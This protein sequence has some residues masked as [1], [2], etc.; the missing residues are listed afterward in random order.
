MDLQQLLG[1]IT[2][3]YTRA[4]SQ[5]G[6]PRERTNPLIGPAGSALGSL[7][8]SYAGGQGVVPNPPVR[9]DPIRPGPMGPMMQPRMGPGMGPGM[10]MGPGAM[11]G[12]AGMLSDRDIGRMGGMGP[13]MGMR[14]GAMMG[15]AGM[16]SD[17]D[18]GRM[19]PG[20]LQSMYNN[21]LFN[22]VLRQRYLGF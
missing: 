7:A 17:R 18:I 2:D 15:R 1:M 13:G 9:Q 20:P 8:S 5:G 22:P 16:L 14:S 12:R 19:N 4:F 6:I 3:P 21:S 11:M 10:G